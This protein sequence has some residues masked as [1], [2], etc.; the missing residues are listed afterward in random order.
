MKTM[1]VSPL[2]DVRRK[3]G[4]FTLMEII[5]VMSIM[6]LM[7]GIGVASFSFVSNS[8]PFEEPVARLRKMSK[9]ALQA[10]VIQHR[11][12]KIAFDKTGFTLIGATDGGGGGSYTLPGGMKMQILHFGGKQWEKAENQVWPFGEQGICE[13]IRIRFLNDTDHVDLAFH[14]LTGVPLDP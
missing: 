3:R 1:L 9:Y 4:G 13:P 11:S 7:I 10:A 14:P 5:V 2:S 6:M 8:D 12:M